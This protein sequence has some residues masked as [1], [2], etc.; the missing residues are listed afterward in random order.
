MNVLKKL[1][2]LHNDVCRLWIRRTNLTSIFLESIATWTKGNNHEVANAYC[3][4]ALAIYRDS[5]DYDGEIRVLQIQGTVE[6]EYNGTVRCL[7]EG[8][9]KFSSLKL[10]EK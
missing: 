9:T 1:S 4:K 2:K 8:I 7:T 10:Y 5:K 3:A 6:M